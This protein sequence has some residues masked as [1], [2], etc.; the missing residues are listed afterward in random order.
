MLC[1]PPAGGPRFRRGPARR[2]ERGPASGGRDRSRQGAV[3]CPAGPQAQFQ[4]PRGAPDGGQL[5]QAGEGPAE[6]TE[7]HQDRFPRRPV[8]HPGGVRVQDA[9]GNPGQ[10]GQGAEGD[11]LRP[12]RAER[13]LGW[14]AG[15]GGAQDG[16]VAPAHRRQQV[17]GEGAE[18]V[19][20][21]EVVQGVAEGAVLEV[22]QGDGGV[23]GGAPAGGRRGH[24]VVGGGRV[25]VGEGEPGAGLG[26]D[27]G[28]PL[29]RGPEPRLGGA[30]GA[31]QPGPYPLQPS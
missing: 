22:Q 31:V 2:A 26:V 5:R 6:A 23:S 27:G 11:H 17:A 13:A 14:V 30:P 25:A 16:A 1:H 21:G 19:P 7:R 4:A 18:D 12:G 28:D 9:G 8:A 20:G 15:E 10:E 29:A 3:P 24:V